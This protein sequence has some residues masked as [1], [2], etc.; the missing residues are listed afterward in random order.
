[1]DTNERPITFS[2]LNRL[3]CK[4]DFG[5]TCSAEA[6]EYVE[7]AYYILRRVE[8]GQD[9]AEAIKQVHYTM[10]AEIELPQALVEKFVDEYF[11]PIY[12][13]LVIDETPWTPLQE[14]LFMNKLT[15]KQF[16][17]VKQYLLENG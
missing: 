1:M 11:N 16:E 6:D 15:D 12:E 13:E 2:G 14:F 7:E 10:F 4:Y 3:L 5:R 17:A 8:D 9:F